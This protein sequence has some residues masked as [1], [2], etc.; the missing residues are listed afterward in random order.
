MFDHRT[1]FAGRMR[2]SF[3]RDAQDVSVRR[4]LAYARKAVEL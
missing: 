1:L 4:E 3:E 2:Q